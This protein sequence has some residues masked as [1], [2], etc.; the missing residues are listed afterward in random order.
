M[1]LDLWRPSTVSSAHYEQACP[2]ENAIYGEI[3]FMDVYHGA[4]I[5]F[6]SSVPRVPG[7]KR[8]RGMGHL[9]IHGA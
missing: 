3:D 4:N 2:S 7:D 9:S 6:F 5:A 8:E 1:R